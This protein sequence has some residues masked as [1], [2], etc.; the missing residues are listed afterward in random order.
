MIY[1]LGLRPRL[2][3]RLAVLAVATLGLC[4]VTAPPSIAPI[5][6][7]CFG[8]AHATSVSYGYQPVQ[9]SVGTIHTSQTHQECASDV[10]PGV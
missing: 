1:P 4:L 2:H 5:E 7:N 3:M 8:L 10:H 6:L 9:K